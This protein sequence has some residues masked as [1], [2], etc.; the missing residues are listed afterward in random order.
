MSD[1]NNPPIGLGT[2]VL[3]FNT[4]LGNDLTAAGSD[5]GR[6][7]Q[8]VGAAV[9][10]TSVTLAQTSAATASSLAKTLV[11]VI[12]VQAT[13]FDDDGVATA[14]TS[15]VRTLPLIDFIDPAFYQWTQVRLQGQFFVSELA[16]ANTSTS[17]TFSSSD[18][19]GQ[20]GLFVFLGGG[21]TGTGFQTSDTSVSSQS[22]TAIA[23]GRARM[24]AQLN[25]RTDTGVPRPTKVTQGPT[26][27]IVEGDIANT[28]PT[29]SPL[30]TR[31]MSLLLILTAFDGTP[32]ANK[33]ISIETDGV[34][35]EFA[36]AGTTT[37]DASGQLAIRLRR[38]FLPV[39]AGAPPGTTQ[40][41]SAI[42]VVVTARL[43]LVNTSTTVQV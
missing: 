30:V 18:N 43:G 26:L 6:L 27:Q 12:A 7:I 5:F 13:N 4:N 37:T 11:D 2:G 8:G 10:A 20:H 14:S 21:Q 9:A 42:E 16:S 40:D 41:I 15:F 3:A 35:W 29:G 22:D 36:T 32:I 39:P 34:P 19:S 25:P 23:V 24:F 33:A 28:P 17:N 31:T 38:D 1:T